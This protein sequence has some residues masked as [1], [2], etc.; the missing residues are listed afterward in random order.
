M[1]NVEDMNFDSSIF[2]RRP[3]ASGFALR[4]TTRQVARSIDADNI[5]P[6]GPDIIPVALRANLNHSFYFSSIPCEIYH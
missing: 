5:R 4:A 6:T 1:P 3:L 2:N